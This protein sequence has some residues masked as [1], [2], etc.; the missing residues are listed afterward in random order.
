[1]ADF[2][3]KPQRSLLMSRIRSHGNAATE[4]RFIMLLKELGITGWRRRYRLQGNPDFVFPKSRLA[5]FVD[6]CFWHGCPRCYNEPKSNRRFWR[7]KILTNRRRAVLVNRALRSSG[8]LVLR[9]W[10]HELA[11]KN[12][13][14]CVKRIR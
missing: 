4:M 10:Q 8:W 13:H 3:T 14:R 1:M 2:L 6:G 12:E 7:Q 9:V 5:I 11:L